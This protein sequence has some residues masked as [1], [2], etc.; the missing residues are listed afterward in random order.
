[1]ADA[2]FGIEPATTSVKSDLLQ[3]GFVESIEPEE[4]APLLDI[5]F[6]SNENTVDSILNVVDDYQYR[7]FNSNVP[8]DPYNHYVGSESMKEFRPDLLESYDSAKESD[9]NHS[10]DSIQRLPDVASCP[11]LITSPDSSKDD[12]T[13]SSE[14]QSLNTSEICDI[15]STNADF[16]DAELYKCLQEHEEQEG[17]MAVNYNGSNSA[18]IVTPHSDFSDELIAEKPL[19]C[20]DSISETKDTLSSEISNDLLSINDNDEPPQEEHLNLTEEEKVIFEE[21]LEDSSNLDVSFEENK[22]NKQLE[23]ELENILEVSVKCELTE[24]KVQNDLYEHNDIP[25]LSVVPDSCLELESQ[26]DLN[27]SNSVQTLNRQTENELLVIDSN[28][29]VAIENNKLL[30]ESEVECVYPFKKEPTDSLCSIDSTETILIKDDSQVSV[31]TVTDSLDSQSTCSLPSEVIG[32]TIENL[33]DSHIQRPSTLDLNGTTNCQ[34]ELP[35]TL[36]TGIFYNFTVRFYLNKY[37]NFRF[38]LCTVIDWTST[39]QTTTILGTRWSSKKLHAM[40]IEIYC[41]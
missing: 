41:C 1:M 33:D 22:T 37:L 36:S 21:I 4:I 14:I 11:V 24:D 12:C 28:N 40:P 39:W 19:I 26:H 8:L 20:D 17:L 38:R 2:D 9:K 6:T 3:N 29:V 5:D 16:S 15:D 35:S 7:P 25:N 32:D 10:I 31:N 34:T 18:G 27:D 30:S 13:I 23:K